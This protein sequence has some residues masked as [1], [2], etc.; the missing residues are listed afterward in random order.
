MLLKRKPEMLLVFIAYAIV[1]RGTSQT[2]LSLKVIVKCFKN[3]NR[4]NLF[5]C[6]FK[7]T[8]SRNF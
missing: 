8:I 2:K 1:V 5:L 7:K 3:T 4:K 6:I